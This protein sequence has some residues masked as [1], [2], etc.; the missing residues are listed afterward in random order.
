MTRSGSRFVQFGMGT[1]LGGGVLAVVTLA[2]SQNVR[3]TSPAERVNLTWTAP[4]GCPTKEDVVAEVDRLLGASGARPAKPIQVSA[5]VTKET[6]GA[7]RVRLATP[8]AGGPRTREVKGASCD[9]V[10]NVTAVI[11]ALMVDPSAAIAVAPSAAPSPSATPAPPS[12]PTLSTPLPAPSPV[13]TIS[14]SA[15]GSSTATSVVSPTAPPPFSS[16]ELPSKP[17]ILASSSSSPAGPTPTGSARAVVQSPPPIAFGVSA[18][19]LLDVGSLPGVA[20]GFEGAGALLFG[21][22]RLELGVSAFPDQTATLSDL[23]SAGGR[24]GLVAGF[25]RACRDIF[26]FIQKNQHFELSPC[27]AFELG[28]LHAKGFGVESPD[29]G[30]ALWLAARVGA[31][32]VWRP[33]QRFALSV[34]AGAVFPFSRPSFTIEGAGAVFRSSTVA[35]RFSF[36][37]EV[38]F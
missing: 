23:P 21:A 27:V 2:F 1:L 24:I 14:T 13:P 4:S 12:D 34:Q 20:P 36:G 32:F 28:R 22:Y 8:A 16:Y 18:A 35:G 31:S 26:P 19:A 15:D 38:R 37:A 7:F 11:L 10:A 9:A 17:P 3:P 29:E 25:A 6:T 30:E 33:Q 5:S